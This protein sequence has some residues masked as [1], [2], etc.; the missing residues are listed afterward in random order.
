[1]TLFSLTYDLIIHD[2]ILPLATHEVFGDVEPRA[3]VLYVAN[4]DDRSQDRV[5]YMASS[6]DFMPEGV[7]E[8]GDGTGRSRDL[9]DDC[10]LSA[11]ASWFSYLTPEQAV[12][13][14]KQT[15]H[16]RKQVRL[17]QTMASLS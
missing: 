17:D 7:L 11:P 4:A 12:W 8:V 14:D 1:M 16:I 6:A 10:I 13:F 2:Q 3:I 5:W 15:K 9:F